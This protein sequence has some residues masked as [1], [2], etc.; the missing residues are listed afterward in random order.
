MHSPKVHFEAH[1]NSLIIKF[2]VNC[3]KIHSNPKFT[4]DYRKNWGLWEFDVVECFI[5]SRSNSECYNDEYLEFQLSP[6][7]QEF[8][9]KI[10][11]PREVYYTP[12]DLKVTSQVNSVDS[13]WEASIEI[14]FENFNHTEGNQIFGNFHACLGNENDRGYFSLWHNDEKVIDFH[15]PHDFKRLEL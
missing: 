4:N 1:Q 6:L 13:G 11:K 8:G 15:R 14:P 2:K 12:L 7:G 9:L 5:Q 3:L 10:K